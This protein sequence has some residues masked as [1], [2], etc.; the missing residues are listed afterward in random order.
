VGVGSYITPKAVKGT[1]SAIEGRGVHAVEPIARGEVVAVKGGHIID[2]R[3]LTANAEMIGNSD[4]Q[5]AEGIYLAAMDRSEYEDLMMFLNHS[6]EPNVGV[7]GNVVFVA[8][9][10]ISPG[11]ELTVD[12]AMIDD[13]PHEMRCHCATRSCRGVVSGQDWRRPDLQERYGPYFSWFLQQ[14][15]RPQGSG[16]VPLSGP[17]P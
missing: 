15:F 2:D 16:L 17:A 4:L 11:E 5:I 1:T 6:C 7:A 12:Y 14:K 13:G 8:M 9:R 3:T 10:D